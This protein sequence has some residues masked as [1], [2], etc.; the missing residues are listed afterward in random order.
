MAVRVAPMP[1]RRRCVYLADVPPDVAHINK[2]LHV[3]EG[4]G[5]CSPWRHLHSSRPSDATSIAVRAN[6][7]I[8]RRFERARNTTPFPRDSGGD[9]VVHQATASHHPAALCVPMSAYVVSVT[10]IGEYYIS[11]PEGVQCRRG[12]ITNMRQHIRPCADRN[13][14]GAH[15]HHRRR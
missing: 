13:R 1:F 5:A 15:R 6:G 11:V 10:V 3:R 4:R 8:R 14:R 9:S 7:R 2:K 12:N